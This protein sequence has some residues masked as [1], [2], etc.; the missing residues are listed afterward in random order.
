MLPIDQAEAALVMALRDMA[1]IVSAYLFGSSVTG[2]TH[3]ESDLDLGVL[4]DRRVHAS[5][6]DRF[7]VRL[8]LAGHCQAL[9]GQPVD[10]V[11][12]NDAPPHLA[13]RVMTEGRRILTIDAAQDHAHLRLMLSR[14][15]DLKPFLERTRGIKLAWLTQ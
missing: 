6:A 9:L 4:L 11:I 7:E 12:L 15:A 5:D 8:H 14:A 10:V 1:G 3:R 2:R 13:R